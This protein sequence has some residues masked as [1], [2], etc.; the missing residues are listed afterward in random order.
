MSFSEVGVS[1]YVPV[2]R[3]EATKRIDRAGQLVREVVEKDCSE[4]EIFGA[5]WKSR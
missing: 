1:I 4:M 2:H 3:S 5:W